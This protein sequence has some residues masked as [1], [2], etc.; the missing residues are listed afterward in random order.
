MWNSEA[1]RTFSCSREIQKSVCLIPPSFLFPLPFFLHPSSTHTDQILAG[2]VRP[3]K[4]MT[5]LLFCVLLPSM[6]VTKSQSESATKCSS[7]QYPPLGMDIDISIAIRSILSI[8]RDPWQLK[9]NMS[10]AF[11]VTTVEGKVTSDG[12]FKVGLTCFLATKFHSVLLI[13]IISHISRKRKKNERK[14]WTT[15]KSSGT[16]KL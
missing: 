9:N 13:S 3:C 8:N 15:H 10:A 4:N 6:T 12:I 1:P 16:N 5:E 7:A 2:M 11:C 14:R